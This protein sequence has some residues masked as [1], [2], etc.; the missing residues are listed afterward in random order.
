[1][2]PF[3]SVVVDLLSLFPLCFGVP[4][5]SKVVDL[6]SRAWLQICTADWLGSSEVADTN[7]QMLCTC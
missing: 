4:F 1:M 6:A 3:S 2:V 5:P 7:G